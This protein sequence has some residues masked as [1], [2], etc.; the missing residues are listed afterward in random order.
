[1]NGNLGNLNNQYIIL[2]QIDLNK[3]FAKKNQNNEEYLIEFRNNNN[4]NDNL[5][6]NLINLFNALNNAYNP[7]ILRFIDEG[8]GQL[9]LNNEPPRNGNYFVFEKAP[10]SNLY[11]YLHYQG[12]FSE[13]HAKLIF[14]KILNGVA[15]IHN[16]NYCHLDLKPSNILFD[17]YFNPKISGFNFCRLNANNLNGRVGTQNYQAPEILNGQPYDGIKCDIFS[18]GQILFNLVSGIIGFTSARNN[19]PHYQLII[20]HNYEQYWNSE[21]FNGL[22]LSQD[23]KD[24]VIRL[25]AHDPN[26][27]PTIEEILQSNWMQ[28]VMT[29]NNEQMQALDREVHDELDNIYHKFNVLYDDHY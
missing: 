28:E 15:A 5:H 27:R 12:G 6:A 8:N 24:L 2:R 21:E 1:M 29:M 10:K 22:N 4:N 14:K 3:F 18:L 11:Y 9:A 26:Q 23:F 16:A 19:D 17:T 13:R 25:F 7:N 20:N